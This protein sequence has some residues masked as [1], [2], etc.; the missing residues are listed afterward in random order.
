MGMLTWDRLL[1]VRVSEAWVA[2]PTRRSGIDMKLAIFQWRK[3]QFFRDGR[4][5]V[6]LDQ[7]RH[8]PKAFGHNLP[9]LL[10]ALPSRL[11]S[12]RPGQPGQKVRLEFSVVV[13]Y[14]FGC[15]GVMRR[16]GFS[17]SGRE[18]GVVLDPQHYDSCSALIGY[19]SYLYVRILTKWKF[20]DL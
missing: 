16:G 17:I 13:I 14:C 8:G 4:I 11:G 12:K 6:M 1:Y 15:I 7:S 19:E 10:F 5:H 3:F 20:M 2:N 9:I 18:C